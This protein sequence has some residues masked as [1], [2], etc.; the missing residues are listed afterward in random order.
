[1]SGD[2][3]KRAL[4]TSPDY[5]VGYGKPPPAS[6]FKPGQSGNPKGRPRG[7][8]NRKP[9]LNEE[10]LKD[11]VLEE[12]YREISVRDGHRNVTLPMAQAIIRALSVNAAKG[13]HRSQ[14]LFAEMLATTERQNKALADAWLQTAIEYKVEW[15]RELERRNALGITHLPDPVPH[16]D[17]V[18][19]D[20]DTGQ[21]KIVGPMTKEEKA[22]LDWLVA[23]RDEFRDEITDLR[24]D[25]ETEEDAGIRELMLEDIRRDEEIVAKLDVALKVVGL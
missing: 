9:N 14:R 2:K 22:E 4:V 25:L 6:R 23:R 13:D 7:S 17:H 8:K 18:K 3:N 16:P 5:D 20:M 19:I 1:M 15:D 10:R 24:Q 11:I 21:A 12:A